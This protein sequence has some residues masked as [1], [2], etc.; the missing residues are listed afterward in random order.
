MHINVD[1]NLRNRDCKIFGSERKWYRFQCSCNAYSIDSERMKYKAETEKLILDSNLFQQNN[2]LFSIDVDVIDFPWN[3]WSCAKTRNQYC[4]YLLYS[5]NCS[6]ARLSF[7][8]KAIVF[9]L[10]KQPFCESLD[11]IL[12]LKL[13]P[14][15]YW[16]RVSAGSEP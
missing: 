3:V 13:Q 9:H 4:E 5:L 1:L 16:S 10:L 7:K 11:P 12:L 15:I 14:L 2:N 6:K 8:L